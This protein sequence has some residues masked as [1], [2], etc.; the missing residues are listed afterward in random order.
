MADCYSIF[1]GGF[2]VIVAQIEGYFA[3]SNHWLDHSFYVQP[4]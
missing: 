2:V 3:E 1:L 4:Y